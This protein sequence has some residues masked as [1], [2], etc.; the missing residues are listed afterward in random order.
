MKF[1][2]KISEKTMV[3]LV[4]RGVSVAALALSAASVYLDEPEN[5]LAWLLGI[6]TGGVVT[7]L[8]CMAEDLAEEEK[9]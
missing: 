5:G 8:W 3:K 9:S 2:K 4:A 1:P 7:L 6:A